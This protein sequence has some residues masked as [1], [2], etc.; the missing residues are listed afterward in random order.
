MLTIGTTSYKKSLDGHPD[1]QVT[2]SLQVPVPVVGLTPSQNP[3]F[4]D[5]R[6]KY[7]QATDPEAEAEVE[8]ETETGSENP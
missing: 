2:S 7:L 3:F 4:I 1:I 5:G 8:A 6:T